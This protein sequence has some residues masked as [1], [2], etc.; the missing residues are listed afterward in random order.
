MEQTKIN[1]ENVSFKINDKVIL[2]NI[3]FSAKQGEIIG[4]V[5]DNG[6]GKSTLLKIITGLLHET[7]GKISKTGRNS[8]SF[9]TEKDCFFSWMSVKDNLKFFKDLSKNEYFYDLDDC[10][11]KLNLSKYKDYEFH[12]LSKGNKKKVNICNSIFRDVDFLIMDEPMSGL[13]MPSRIKVEELIKEF[14]TNKIVLISTH[15]PNVI[16][17]LCDKILVVS[18]NQ[19]FF[20]TIEELSNKYD[21]P[22]ENFDLQKHL[23][24]LMSKEENIYG[25]NF[26]ETI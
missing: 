5:G 8:V 11:D 26:E 4:L 1:L 24:R 9:C 21:L 19:L 25:N 2:N 10:I 3:S 15:D 7:N 22:L 13:D 6:A 12:K 18:C 23:S 17:N 20:G 14:S 16:K